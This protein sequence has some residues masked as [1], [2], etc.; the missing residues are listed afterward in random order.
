MARLAMR[1]NQADAVA[2]VAELRSRDLAPVVLKGVGVQRLLYPGEVRASSDVDL[3]VAPGEQRRAQ[4]AL[5]E[6]GF[7]RFSRVG[8]ATSW[9][10]PGR[11]PVDL[12][13]TLPYSRAG[14]RQVWEALAAHRTTIVVGEGAGGG[15]AATEITVLDAPATAVHLTIHL[16]QGTTDRALEDL[17][18]AVDVL[19][20]GEWRTAHEVATALG[21]TP[22]LAWALGQVPGGEAVRE[23][24]GLA[25]LGRHELPAGKPSEGGIVRFAT[26]SV[27]W[28]DRL[29]TVVPMVRRVTSPRSLEVW[30]AAHGRPR[31]ATRRARMATLAARAGHELRRAS[32]RA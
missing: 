27:H 29:P 24:L 16:T 1:R 8:H 12:H 19:S 17:R 14:A 20:A 6:L 9:A 13:R 22:S 7:T 15:G 10:A 4:R 26:S 32:T 5:G 11:T 21:T 3:L 25:P 28:R 2:I 31:P 23:A 18:R 30:A